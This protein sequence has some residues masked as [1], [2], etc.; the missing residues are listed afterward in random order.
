MFVEFHK[1]N[2]QQTTRN[3]RRLTVASFIFFFGLRGFVYTDWY[4]YYPFFNALPTIGDNGLY[5]VFH[6][7]TYDIGFE[8]YAVLIKS[9][10]PNYFFW[11]FISSCID[12]AILHICFKRYAPNYYVFGFIVFFIL[13][14]DIMEINLMRNVKAILLFMLSLRYLQERKIAPY[15]LLNL[16]GVS[17]HLSAIVYFPLYFLLHKEFSKPFLWTIFIV[18]NIIFLFQISYIQ[19]IFTFFADIIGP[20][21]VAKVQTYFNYSQYNK[22]Y[23]MSIGYFERII[24]Y[25]LFLL[26]YTKL[27]DQ[28][29]HNIVLINVFVLYFICF[30]YFAEIRGASVRMAGLFIFAYW[31]LYPNLYS[32]LQ[33]KG[34]RMLFMIL[35]FCTSIGRVA[36]HNNNLLH[37]YDNLIFGIKSYEVRKN[38]FEKYSEI[39]FKS[40]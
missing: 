3:V 34:N 28:H 33:K 8:L 11:I 38:N 1:I 24:S 12:M 26:F 21:A 31:L 2:K 36:I 15:M 25:I 37:E 23:G 29:R 7:S 17:F 4:N 14:G 18:G 39:I 10:W 32:V 19:P 22:P 6:N 9:L 35:F 13:G 40:N 27:K 5:H 16:I 30:F 20:Q